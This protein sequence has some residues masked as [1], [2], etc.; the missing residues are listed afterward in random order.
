MNTVLTDEEMESVFD[1]RGVMTTGEHARAIE[2]LV[3]RKLTER[4]KS[5][6]AVDADVVWDAAKL[7]CDAAKMFPTEYTAKGGFTPHKWVT[8]AVMRGIEQGRREGRKEVHAEHLAIQQGQ[9]EQYE[10]LQTSLIRA[11]MVALAEA[12]M[13]GK[14]TIS[15]KT[16]QKRSHGKVISSEVTH[17]S[18][19]IRINL[20]DQRTVWDRVELHTERNEEGTEVLFT[21]TRK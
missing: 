20:E 11:N 9:A 14:F 19:V 12:V 21:V 5:G 4:S 6:D 16:L 7:A 17:H 1:G 13:N 10:G 8:E 3:L 2:Q 15:K 18:V